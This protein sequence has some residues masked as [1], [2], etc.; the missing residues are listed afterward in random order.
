MKFTDS[1]DLARNFNDCIIRYN[2]ALYLSKTE[3][4]WIKCYGYNFPEAP[5]V[6]VR[7]I[8]HRINGAEEFFIEEP[9]LGYLPIVNAVYQIVRNPKRQWVFGLSGANTT[10]HEVRLSPKERIFSQRG[11]PFD[12]TVD[13][14]RRFVNNRYQPLDEVLA[15]G[16]GALN[17]KVAV[18][19][20]KVLLEN[21]V[22][23]DITK[24]KKLVLYHE[25]RD[26][27]I[28][29]DALT[30]AGLKVF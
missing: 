10:I 17:R 9:Q 5:T 22:V 13:Y 30:N 29:V 14:F 3:G 16:V 21:C 26:D 4:L 1:A 7:N 8:Q 19:K 27:S 23:G 18:L 20:G 25:K 12:Y 24:D 6:F 11:V 15:T 28:V 2:G